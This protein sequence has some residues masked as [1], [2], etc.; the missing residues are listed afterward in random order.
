[1]SYESLQQ[2]AITIRGRRTIKMFEQRSVDSNIIRDA[3]EVARWAPNHHLTE[4]W[5]FYLLND[6]AIKKSIDLIRIIVTEKNGEKLGNFKAQD[7]SKRPGWLIV[8]CKK[9]EDKLVQQE[10]YASVCCAI[11]NFSLYLSEARLASKWTSGPIIRDQRYYD[12]LHIDSNS[13]FIVGLIWY[14]YPMITPKQTR[15]EIDK[16]ITSI[17]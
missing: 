9:S 1:M 11:Q 17:D 16:I 6:V 15:K 3:I 7:A 2:L 13:E 4:P 12:L 8:T 5:H 10:D 14:G